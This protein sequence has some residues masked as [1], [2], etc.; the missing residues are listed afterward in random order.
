M[1]QCA[2]RQR[3]QSGAVNRELTERQ[4]SGESLGHVGLM[5]LEAGEPTPEQGAAGNAE[6][7]ETLHRHVLL[8]LRE[9]ERQGEDEGELEKFRRREQQ[10]RD[11]EMQECAEALKAYVSGEIPAKAATHTIRR[12]RLRTRRVG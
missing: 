1:A 10:R 3:D 9:R 5:P 12:P 4:R 7:M 2:D 11:S 8:D 6:Y